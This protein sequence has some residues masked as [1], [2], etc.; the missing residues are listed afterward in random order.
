VGARTGRLTVPSTW[1]RRLKAAK[2][3]Y[4]E[5]YFAPYRSQIY[6]SYREQRDL[7]LI[8]TFSDMLGVP[9]PAAFYALE[10]YP[11]LIEEF[12]QWHLRMGMDQA[13]EG[14]FRCC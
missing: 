10:L 8:M 1:R 13:P 5:I 7:F 2:D 11:D 12:H 6:R 4:E 3:I 9:N 14:G